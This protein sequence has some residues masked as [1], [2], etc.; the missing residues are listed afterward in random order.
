[1]FL[2]NLYCVKEIGGLRK[3]V[4]WKPSGDNKDCM[5]NPSS[6]GVNVFWCLGSRLE[7]FQLDRELGTWRVIRPGWKI[8]EQ[9]EQQDQPLTNMAIMLRPVEKHMQKIH[10]TAK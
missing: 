10:F 5:L 4:V 6:G 9:R 7:R 3:C 1:M 8:K 2:H